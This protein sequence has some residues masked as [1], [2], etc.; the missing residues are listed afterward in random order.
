MRKLRK[1]ILVLAL[2]TASITMG[3]F[4]TGLIGAGELEPPGPPGPTMKTLDQIQPTWSQ[5]L[6]IEERFER[7]MGGEAILDKETGL[8]WAAN[9]DLFGMLDW[10][11]A[12][13]ACADLSLGGRKGW[14]LPEREELAS[15]VDPSQTSPAVPPG[16]GFYFRNVQSGAYWSSTTYE[17]GNNS[18]WYVSMYTGVVGVNT[19]VVSRYVWP[20]RSGR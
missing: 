8:T 1:S 15:L 13:D 9:A 3:L 11:G 6:P 19:R 16:Y 12:I 20:V 5:V 17:S 10:Q 2:I 7:V 14:R 4:L 18:V